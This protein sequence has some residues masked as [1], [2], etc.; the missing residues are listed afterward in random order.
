MGEFITEHPGL[1]RIVR[2]GLAPAIAMSTLAVWIRSR[3]EGGHSTL[4]GAVFSGTGN[5]AGYAGAG[6]KS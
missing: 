5:L 6:Q 2:V 1:K 3:R 4:A